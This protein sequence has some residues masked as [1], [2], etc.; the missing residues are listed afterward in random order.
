MRRSQRDVEDEKGMD[1]VKFDGYWI[2]GVPYA[3]FTLSSKE[4]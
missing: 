3:T 2:L 1:E 4:W